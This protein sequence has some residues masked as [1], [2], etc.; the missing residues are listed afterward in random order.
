MSNALINNLARTHTF[1]DDLES[2]IYILMWRTLMYSSINEP[3]Q[4]RLFLLHT[5]DPQPLGGEG[6]HAKAD[7]LIGKSFLNHYRFPERDALHKLVDNLADIF[8][9]HYSVI[10]E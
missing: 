6:G 9:V 7:F 8:T 3:T 10:S 5:L 1:V 2:A 4:A